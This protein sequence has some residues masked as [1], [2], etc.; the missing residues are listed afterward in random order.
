VQRA[1]KARD[2]VS[3]LSAKAAFLWEIAQYCSMRYFSNGASAMQIDANARSILLIA[4]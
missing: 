4:S 2:I 1:K 3:A